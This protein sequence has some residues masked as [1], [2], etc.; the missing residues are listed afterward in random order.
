MPR[1]LV[2]YTKAKQ[3]RIQ[4][5]IEL[6]DGPKE[7]DLSKPPL[8]EVTKAN[9]ITASVRMG[10][11][12]MYDNNSNHGDEKEEEDTNEKISQQQEPKS[13]SKK[14]NNSSS[15]LNKVLDSSSSPFDFIMQELQKQGKV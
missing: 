4:D 15:T 1:H 12:K 3:N 11:P 5:V 6:V 9:P 2:S 7:I 14:K 8:I 13:S 10:K